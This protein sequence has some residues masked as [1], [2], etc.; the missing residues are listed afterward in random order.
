MLIPMIPAIPPAPVEPDTP[1]P[2][3]SVMIPTY[4]SQE[5]F[6][7]KTLE[8]VLQQDPGADQM[9]IEVVDDCSPDVNV[10]KIVETIAGARVKVTGTQKNLGLAGCFNTC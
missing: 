4:R 2:F 10:G 7:R 1:P 5:T 9:Q 8:S 3:W 6:L